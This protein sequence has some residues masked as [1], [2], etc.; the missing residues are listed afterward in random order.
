MGYAHT[1]LLVFM[2][3][4]LF[5]FAAPRFVFDLA[6]LQVAYINFNPPTYGDLPTR[7]PA[8]TPSFTPSASPSRSYGSSF[9]TTSSPSATPSRIPLGGVGTAGRRTVVLDKALGFAVHWIPNVNANTITMVV[10]MATSSWSV[11]TAL[12]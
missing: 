12:Y 11:L 6:L 1:A 7:T 8:P 5:L 3:W 9:S 2:G 10:R 4:Y